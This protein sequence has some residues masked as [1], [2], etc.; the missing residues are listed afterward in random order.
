MA[1]NESTNCTN[2]YMNLPN[3]YE[4]TKEMINTLIKA[5]K[6]SNKKF[7]LGSLNIGV[8]YS[9]GSLNSE[10]SLST[11]A[12]SIIDETKELYFDFSLDSDDE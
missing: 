1:N 11:S 12:P 9:N 2:T 6:I 5:P 10:I 7:D 3:E 8:S 4:M